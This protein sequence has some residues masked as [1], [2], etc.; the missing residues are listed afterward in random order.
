MPGQHQTSEQRRGSVARVFELLEHGIGDEEGSVQTDQVQEG[1]GAHGMVQAQ[2]DGRI[3]V[4]PGGQTVLINPYCVQEIGDQQLVDD[5]AWC[6]LGHHGGLAHRLA[7]LLGD[8][9]GLVAG[10]NGAH[11]FEERHHRHGIEEMDAQHL[12]AAFGDG[13]HLG[14]AQRR[15]VAADDG[16]GPQDAIQFIENLFLQFH[17]LDGGLDDQIAGSKVSRICSA[18]DAGQGS[19]HLLLGG[20]AFGHSPAQGLVDAVHALLQEL[21][22]DL[23]DHHLVASFGADLDDAGAHQPTADH[24]YLFD[25]HCFTTSL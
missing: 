25:L 15:G 12:V 2:L 1:Q 24:A 18:L 4:L 8:G 9:Q 7:E 22:I 17:I 20:F 10:Q 19:V 3:N 16:L 13:S 6:V 23:A 21:V 5:K 14:D 11:Q